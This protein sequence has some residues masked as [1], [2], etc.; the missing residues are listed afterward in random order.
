M[1]QEVIYEEPNGLQHGKVG[2]EQRSL[3]TKIDV[4]ITEK[5]VARP[6]GQGSK[7]DCSQV[8][9]SSEEIGVDLSVNSF[10]DRVAKEVHYSI[11]D[12]LI[13]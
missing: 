12:N 10:E 3:A 9:H 1:V 13:V 5:E 11:M 6:V 4:C 2:I 7:R 8:M